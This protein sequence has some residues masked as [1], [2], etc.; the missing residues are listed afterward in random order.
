MIGMVLS[1]LER[2]PYADNTIVALW[3][4]HGWHL[5]EKRSWRKF[6]LWE[7]SARTPMI[8]V[9]PRRTTSAGRSTSR[10][11]GLIDLYP[12]LT[13]LCGL[14]TPPDLD[15]VSLHPLL[16]DPDADTPALRE[17]ELTIN[18]R[19]N[20]SLRDEQYRYTRYFDGSEE[21]YDHQ[22]DPYEWTNL[23]Y[24]RAFDDV[25]AHYASLLPEESV[26][27][28]EPRGFC[29][30]ADLDKDDMEQWRTNVWPKWLRE[31]LPPLI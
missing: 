5:G 22:L 6:T 30:W 7:E 18:G 1:E 27:T 9:D 12:T 23:A 15:G 28:M 4:D 11:V 31:A 26:P 10:P 24:E 17:A 8:I 13:D 3:S 19:G 14:P 29:W 2:S 25:R 16:D 20:C 21:L